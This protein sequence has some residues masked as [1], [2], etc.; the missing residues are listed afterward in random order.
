MSL[1]YFVALAEVQAARVVE[2]KELRAIAISPSGT[3]PLWTR[4][5][6]ALES[7]FRECNRRGV[8]VPMPGNMDTL[9]PVTSG[10][11]GYDPMPRNHLCGRTYRFIEEHQVGTDGESIAALL[12]VRIAVQDCEQWQEMKLL[13]TDKRGE[14]MELHGT[15]PLPDTTYD[16]MVML[17][18]GM[19]FRT[20]MDVCVAPEYYFRCNGRC[21]RS[22]C[23]HPGCVAW[24]L[25]ITLCLPVCF[26][27][28]L[29]CEPKFDPEPE[30]CENIL[31]QAFVWSPYRVDNPA[32][33]SALICGACLLRDA[34]ESS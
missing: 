10:T 13:T 5:E 29:H 31:G 24:L 18:S 2:R 26:C 15:L 12:E 23:S 32:K 27:I 30:A 16:I 34:R 14:R 17:Y 4:S 19:D 25:F 22:T 1:T 33:P 20:W 8:A 3:L 28:W 6:L 21:S 9:V 7:F 11:G